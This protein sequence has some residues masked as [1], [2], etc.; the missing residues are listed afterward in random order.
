MAYSVT[1][2]AHEIGVRLALGAARLDP[3]LA[4]RHE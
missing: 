4:L 3:T 2:R 1:E